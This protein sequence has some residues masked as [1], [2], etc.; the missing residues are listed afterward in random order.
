[1]FIYNCFSVSVVVVVVVCF[2]MDDGDA[3]KLFGLFVGVVAFDVVND[4]DKFLFIGFE[5]IVGV[6]CCVFFIGD[7]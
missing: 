3:D 4:D 1:M 7:V 6:I 2:I 5:I